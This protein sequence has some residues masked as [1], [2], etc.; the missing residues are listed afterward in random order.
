[1]TKN[2]ILKL[3]QLVLSYIVDNIYSAMSH[4]ALASKIIEDNETVA[5]THRSVRG[6]VSTLR[7]AQDQTGID[8][9]TSLDIS[10]YIY[11]HGITA[12]VSRLKIIFK[13]LDISYFREDRI[14]ILSKILCNLTAKNNI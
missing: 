10:D 5:L 14:A 12:G 2:E 4:S 13:D 9:L 1:M 8:D 7:K 11:N 6:Y 3:Q